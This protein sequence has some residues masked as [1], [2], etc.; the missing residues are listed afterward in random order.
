MVN[1]NTVIFDLDN[2]IINTESLKNYRSQRKWDKCYSNFDKTEVIYNPNYLHKYYY[3]GIVTNSPRA[4]AKKLLEYHSIKYDAL[5]AY[6]D[7]EQHKPNIEPFEKCLEILEKNYRETISVGDH[8]NDTLTAYNSKI[9]SVGVTWGDG[10]QEE[11]EEN[12]V[13]LTVNNEEELDTLLNELLSSD[14]HK[15]F[16]SQNDKLINRRW[17]LKKYYPYRLLTGEVNPNFRANGCGIILDLKQNQKHAI[18]EFYNKVDSKLEKNFPI[19]V[20]PSSNKENIDTGI[21]NL[22]IKLANNGREDA[23]SCLVRTKSIQK[24]TDGGTRN[25]AVHLDSIRV[26]NKHLIENKDVLLIDDVTTSG[27][28]LDACE[29]LLIEAGAKRVVK[30][31]MAKTI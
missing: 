16:K 13:D 30:L 12:G 9:L 17:H 25:I 19:C 28:S 6:H 24:A 22:A 20:V 26:K 10:S 7:T 18:N 21:R 14:Y 11:H 5:V 4:Y 23:T 2:T 3:I 29:Q 27:S 31:A 15:I 1:F 8:F